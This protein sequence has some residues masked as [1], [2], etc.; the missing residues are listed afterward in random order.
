MAHNSTV[1]AQFPELV[2]RH[3][4]ESLAKRHHE[5]RKLHSMTRWNQFVAMSVA[6]LAG[7]CSLRDIVSNLSAQSRKLYHL[8]VGA[9]ARSSQRNFKGS[10]HPGIAPQVL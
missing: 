5:G 7:R 9:V 6:Q 8:G 4:F 1:L 3:E 10:G 2:P